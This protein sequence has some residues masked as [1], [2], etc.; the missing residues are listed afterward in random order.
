MA[1]LHKAYLLTS[2]DAALWQYH[3]KSVWRLCTPSACKFLVIFHKNAREYIKYS[4][5]FLFHLTKNLTT[6]LSH[7]LCA[8]L[9]YIFRMALRFLYDIVIIPC[10]FDS[11]K[12]KPHKADA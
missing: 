10:F 12:I 8:V 2:S 3:T 4:L 5:R 7:N 11:V 6:H 9:P 1:T